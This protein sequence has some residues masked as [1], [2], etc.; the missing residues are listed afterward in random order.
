[1]DS[2]C[3]PYLNIGKITEYTNTYIALGRFGTSD[4]ALVSFFTNPIKNKYKLQF[5][6]V[7]Y[8]LPPNGIA[9]TNY[10]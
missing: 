3:G 7:Y 2:I 1:V 9:D 6:T 4:F 5:T 8:S 10:W